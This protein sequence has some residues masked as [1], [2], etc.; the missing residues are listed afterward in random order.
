LLIENIL[1]KKT[2]QGFE[3]FFT[4][5][6]KQ[7]WGE[8]FERWKPQGRL[9]DFK[10]DGYHVST[11]TV[12]Q[13]HGPEQPDPAITASKIK[14]DFDGAKKHF[15]GR[16]EKWVFVYNQRELPAASGMLVGDLR[17]QNPEIKIN[18]WVRDDVHNFALDLTPEQLAIFLPGLL[19]NHEVSEATLQLMNKFVEQ[20]TV[21]RNAG[22]VEANPA[23]TNQI[24]LNQALEALGDDDRTIRLR[25]LGY[26]KWLDP[27]P[28]RDGI[29][30]LEDKGYSEATVSINIERLNQ[31]GLVKVTSHHILP[32]D[33][34]ICTEAADSLADEFI[35][36]LGEG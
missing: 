5:A 28:I 33:E 31:E 24:T 2:G 6:A 7:R 27:L 16:M 18:V 13:C 4:D 11:K 14:R 12:F 30:L 10:C 22:T 25:I 3:D 8:D 19:V 35:A 36:Q 29:A 26:C 23:P 9:G 21:P 32:Q 20:R 15:G 34:R 17:E 1:L